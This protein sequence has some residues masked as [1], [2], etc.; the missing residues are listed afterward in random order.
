[1]SRQMHK[2]DPAR[3][4]LVLAGGGARGAYQAGV[5]KGIMEI[6]G[7]PD[8]PFGVMTGV[9]VGAINATAL[10]SRADDIHAGV[11]WLDDMWSN[12]HSSDVYCTDFI[13]IFSSATRWFLGLLLGGFG[14]SVPSSLFDTKPLGKLL[15]K[16]LNFG[17]LK[18]ALESNQLQ[19]LAV[20]ASS[21]G[22]SHAKTF[23]QTAKPHANWSRERR[24]GI[25]AEITV[26]HVLASTALPVI[27]P[28]QDI[29][30]E[31]FGDGGLRLTSPLSPAI[32]LGA[33]KILVIE[34]RDEKQDKPDLPMKRP[35]LGA[36]IGY[37]MDVIFNDNLKSDVERAKRIN[38]T[39][40]LIPEADRQNAH[41][42]YLD[43]HIIS[44][45]KD[46]RDL[47]ETYAKCLPW[48]VRTLM[49]RIG[50]WKG[51]WRVPSYLLFEPP[52]LRAL[53]DMGYQDAMDNREEL[54]A[55]FSEE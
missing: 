36:I 10:A 22:D 37:L 34:T 19:A 32:R 53:M 55:F 47:T 28:T 6:Y 11:Q 1:M 54:E 16:K 17:K 40:D 26:E 5:L 27:F 48:T 52:F 7:K 18:A 24:D 49:R 42:D 46:V 12:L 25:N 20:T 9:S 44:P 45:S 38:H 3:T 31:Q 33:R 2:F 41:L 35:E 50:A 39:I 13:S 30:G 14:V 21:Y 15:E 29:D 43:I 4:G 8:N 23:F 51:D